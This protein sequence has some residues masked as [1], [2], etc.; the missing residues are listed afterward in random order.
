F[1]VH[2]AHLPKSRAVFGGGTRNRRICPGS[3]GNAVGRSSGTVGRRH[4]AR[5]AKCTPNPTV[6]SVP[7]RRTFGASDQNASLRSRS[8]TN[9][10]TLL[11]ADRGNP[12]PACLASV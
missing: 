9:P 10:L 1:G 7:I 2:F 12:R 6:G 11:G 5:K 3:M 8:Q 4:P